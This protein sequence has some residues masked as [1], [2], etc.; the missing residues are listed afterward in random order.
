M[1]RKCRR[2]RKKY[3][4]IYQASKMVF[5]AFMLLIAFSAKASGF[6]FWNRNNRANKLFYAEEYQKAMELY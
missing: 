1:M 5:C 2:M 6:G 4:I 3:A